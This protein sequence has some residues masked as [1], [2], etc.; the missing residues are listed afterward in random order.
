MPPFYYPYRPYCRCAGGFEL[1]IGAYDI[2][3]FNFL[4]KNALL[5]MLQKSILC[6]LL[7][8][9][10]GASVANPRLIFFFFNLLPVFLH[11]APVSLPLRTE[12]KTF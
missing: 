12:K 1:E 3:N 8:L 10:F 9:C 2:I 5:K 7:L 11:F 6:N 4:F